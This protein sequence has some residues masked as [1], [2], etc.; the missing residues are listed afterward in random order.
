MIAASL[1]LLSHAFALSTGRASEE[2]LQSFMHMTL[3]QI[4]VD[5]FFV[6]SGFLITKSLTQST[7]IKKFVLFRCLRILPA[8]WV[9]LTITIIVAGCFFTSLSAGV[10]FSEPGTFTFLLRNAVLVTGIQHG[11]PGVFESAP[12]PR[13]VNASLWTLPYEVAMYAALA[14]VWILTK[15]FAKFSAARFHILVLLTALCMMTIYLIT[16][17]SR[18]SNL[19][20]LTAFFFSGASL[21]LYREKVRLSWVFAIL[22][23]IVWLLSLSDP[24]ISLRIYAIAVPYITIFL[25]L[26]P[27]GLLKKYNHIGDFS[28][29]LYIYAWPIQQI[30]AVTIQ[31]ITSMQMLVLSF[32]LTLLMAVLSWHVVEKRALAL[33]RY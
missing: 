26:T 23:V 10:F 33:K 25:A 14:I 11:L 29:G 18:P 2:P 19:I 20:R 22:L 27:M 4:A 13:L 12:M 17:E 16:M 15:R 30:L 31:G 21:F 1:V 9:A 32:T 28:Y 6:S 3:A 7:S 24:G 8:L 5:I